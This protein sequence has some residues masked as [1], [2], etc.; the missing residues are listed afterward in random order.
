MTT[1]KVKVK[2]Y[3]VIAIKK[4]VAILLGSKQGRKPK[5]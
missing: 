3:R 4:R 2:I 5:K 1:L